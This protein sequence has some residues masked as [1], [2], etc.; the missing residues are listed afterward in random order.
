MLAVLVIGAGTLVAPT[1]ATAATTFR[2]VPSTSQFHTEITWLA[3]Q[4]ISMGWPD[5]TFRP[6]QSVARDAMAAFLYRLA[7]ERLT[8]HLSSR[9]LPMCQW[10]PNSTKR[11]TGLHRKASPPA[12]QTEPS[13]LSAQSTGTRWRLSSTVSP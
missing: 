13:S 10:E 6:L 12:T 1:Q 7:G 9:G 2:D 5:G 4:E 8:W 11:S 3:T